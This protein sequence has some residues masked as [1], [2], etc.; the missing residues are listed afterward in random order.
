M[1]TK[2]K[3]LNIIGRELRNDDGGWRP[4]LELLNANGDV[5]PNTFGYDYA[6][7]TTTLIRTRSRSQKFF[8]I[9]LADYIPVT[10][11]EGAWLEA[12]TQNL[13]F[14]IAGNFASGIVR[15]GSEAAKVPQVNAGMSPLTIKLVTWAKGYSWSVIELQKA[16]KANQWDVVAARFEALKRH[17]DLGIQFTGFLGLP[18]ESLPGLLTGDTTYGVTVD[19]TTIAANI[20]GMDAT[21]FQAFVAAVLGAYRTNCDRTA[22]PDTFLMPELD[23]LGLAGASSSSFPIGSKLEYLTNAFRLMT[24]NANFQIKGLPYCDLAKNIGYVSVGG[25]NR[26][27]LYRRDIDTLSM[28]IPVDFMSFAPGTRNNYAW[29]GVAAGQFSGCNIYRPKEVLY[30]DHN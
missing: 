14:D 22:W 1:K 30:F 26:Y 20:S 17:W 21:T 3:I 4:G 11:G 28:D 13:T 19:T 25:K 8:Q 2:G 10:V 7:R 23:Y 9:P 29:E 27:V 6:L 18:E 5:D 12:I 15:V 24:G 16:I